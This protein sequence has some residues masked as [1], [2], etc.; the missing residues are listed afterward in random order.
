[1]HL[2]SRIYLEDSIGLKAVFVLGDLR[3]HFS[4][5]SQGVPYSEIAS[6]VGP[7]VDMFLLFLGG[8]CKLEIA[9]IK[10]VAHAR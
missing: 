8:T 9:C 2:V 10:C 3:I 5:C 4:G 1:M 6:G 7:A